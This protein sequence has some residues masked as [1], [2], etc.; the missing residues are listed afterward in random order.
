LA[1]VVAAAPVLPVAVAA[2]FFAL[3]GAGVIT[4]VYAGKSTIELVLAPHGGT[5]TL[6]GIS[7]RACVPGSPDGRASGFHHFVPSIGSL[8][9]DAQ[10]S[11]AVSRIVQFPSWV[12]AISEND[13]C[14]LVMSFSSVAKN[15][16]KPMLERLEFGQMLKTL[17]RSCP[18]LQQLQSNDS[19]ART[20]AQTGISAIN[21]SVI[22]P[23]TC[24]RLHAFFVSC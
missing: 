8:Y 22:L 9:F 10:V 7:L 12:F 2:A 14:A 23:Y 1:F 15:L 5:V 18:V 20:A 17:L 3:Y 19:E 16:L 11:G 6:P 13:R 21:K 24:P 4:V